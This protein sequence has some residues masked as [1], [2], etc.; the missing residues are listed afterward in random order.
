MSNQAINWA[1]QLAVNATLKLV[2]FVL[3]NRANDQGECFPSLSRI[4]KD[5]SLSRASVARA[6][7]QLEFLG[8]IRRTKRPYQ[9]TLY[10]L[11][12]DTNQSHSETSL[13]QTLVSD[14]HITSLTERPPLVSQRDRNP[15]LNPKEPKKKFGVVNGK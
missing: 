8:V 13:T 2:L 5:S 9:A 7:K 3:A 4:S 10:T 12:I 11:L 1:L 14:R 6:L 15:K